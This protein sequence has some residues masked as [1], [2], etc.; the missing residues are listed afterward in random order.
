M[1]GKNPVLS[2]I[3]RVFL[4]RPKWLDNEIFALFLTFMLE[5][6]NGHLISTLMILTPRS[7]SPS[8]DETTERGCGG[9]VGGSG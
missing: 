9:G 2:S 8:E 1:F 6:S 5:L 7:V 4:Y 3:Y